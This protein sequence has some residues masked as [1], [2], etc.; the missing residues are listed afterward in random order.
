MPDTFFTSSRR[1]DG[2]EWFSPTD[3]ARGPWDPDACHGGPPTALLVRALE[4]AV[5]GMRLAARLGRPR[6]AGPDGRLHDRHRGHAR[7]P[8]DGERLG[9]A[10]RRRGRRSAPRPPA[11]TSPSAP[12]ADLRGAHGQQRRADPAAGRQPRPVRSPS[13]GCRHDRPGFRGAVEIRYPP[14][15]DEAPGATTVWMRTVGLLPGEETSPFQRISPL[16]DCGNAFG[17][18]AEPDQVQFVNTDLLIALHRDPVGEWMG[19][20]AV[21]AWQPSGVGLADAL[22][23]DDEGA[24]RAGPADPAAATGSAMSDARVTVARRG[25]R[26][27]PRA[28]RSRRHRL[29]RARLDGPLH[30][31]GAARRAPG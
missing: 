28:R 8:G 31:R 20:R 14:G 24:G 11:C 23:F 30:R 7:R 9:G 3:H 22:L 15:E 10:A 26:P 18:H 12:T 16:A 13:V 1:Q 5:P 21:S 29:V 19:S 25:R 2:S 6:P 4:R 27:R 17:R